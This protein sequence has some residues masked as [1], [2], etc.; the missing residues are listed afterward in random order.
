LQKLFNNVQ[1]LTINSGK[2]SCTALLDQWTIA[3]HMKIDQKAEELQ[4]Q[5]DQLDKRIE[6]NN[7]DWKIFLKNQIETKVG[8]VLTQILQKYEI[9]E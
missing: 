2:R 3:M 1:G 8:C 4:R 9:D 5:I 7:N 6:D